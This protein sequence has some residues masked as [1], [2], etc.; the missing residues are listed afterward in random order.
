MNRS[1]TKALAGDKASE[2]QLFRDL[3]VRFRAIARRRIGEKEG[4]EDIAQQACMVVYQKYKTEKFTS[5]FDAWACGVLR[6]KVLQYLQAAKSRQRRIETSFKTEWIPDAAQSV[7]RE[8]LERDLIDCLQKIAGI[9]SRYARCLI[10]SYH[11]YD[12]NEISGKLNISV[13]AL[14]TTLCRGRA[15]LKKCLKTGEV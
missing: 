13:N 8:E 7:S 10:L 15:I 3:L 9:N 14:Y 12:A 6:M 2:E 11:G 4:A 5:S 1:L